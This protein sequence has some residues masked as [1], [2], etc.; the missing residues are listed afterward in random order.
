MCGREIMNEF[1][2]GLSSN[3]LQ[4]GILVAQI[5]AAIG[6]FTA[7]VVALYLAR[8]QRK[9]DLRFN[10]LFGEHRNFG[11]VSSKNP[12][13][14]L[15]YEIVNCGTT[16]EYVTAICYSVA[17]SRLVG[18]V[19][20]NGLQTLSGKTLPAVLEPGESLTIIVPIKIFFLN[21]FR[22]FQDTLPESK[23]LRRFVLSRSKAFIRVPRTNKKISCKFSSGFKQLIEFG[24]RESRDNN[25]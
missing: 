24:L 13:E 14:S 1:I 8:A 20:T 10:I 6:T 11:W 17:S 2:E 18:A 5:L 23:L 7:A 22:Y 4:F 25:S 15:C 19:D 12:M 16:P 3:Q 21:Q 9:P